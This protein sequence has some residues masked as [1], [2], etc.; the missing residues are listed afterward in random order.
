MTPRHIYKHNL[1]KTLYL[2]TQEPKSHHIARSVGTNQALGTW[3]HT[4][5]T[6]IRMPDGLRN[7]AM[8]WLSSYNIRWRSIA[9]RHLIHYILLRARKRIAHGYTHNITTCLSPPCQE[10][11]SSSARQNMP[12]EYRGRRWLQRRPDTGSHS[13]ARG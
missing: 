3:P 11:S 4:P 8:R 13:P 1:A 9:A 10:E 7:T 5:L 12:R 2:P 6:P